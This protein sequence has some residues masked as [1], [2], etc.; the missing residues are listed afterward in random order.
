MGFRRGMTVALL[1]V[2]FVLCATIGIEI[3]GHGQEQPAGSAR[4]IAV[5]PQQPGVA[6]AEPPNQRDAWF[7]E[8]VSRPLFSP[9]RRPVAADARSVRGLPR[10]TGIITDGSRRTAIFAAPA[11]GRPVVVEAGSRIGPY[12]VRE[13]GD[14]EVTVVG[15]EGTMVVRPIFDPAPAPKVA[16]PVRPELQR[17][18]PK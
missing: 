5:R 4:P 16:P 8:I 2:F 10:L 17:A 9:D 1:L 3:A 18:A 15:P 11:G 6:V 7:K 12:D 13:I 14:A